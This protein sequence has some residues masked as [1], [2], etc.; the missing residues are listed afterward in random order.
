MVRVHPREF[1]FRIAIALLARATSPV[2]S[3][4][5]LTAKQGERANSTTPPVRAVCKG[6]HLEQARK[7]LE[8]ENTMSILEVIGAVVLFIA[9][10]G[11]LLWY[12]GILKV[13]M[14]RDRG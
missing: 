14:E 9:I 1:S 10:V 13:S 7:A 4:V 11:V 2:L 8:Q 6:S 12:A 5:A 3:A